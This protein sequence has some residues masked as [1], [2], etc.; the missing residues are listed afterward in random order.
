MASGVRELTGRESLLVWAGVVVWVGG[1]SGAV[2][3]VVLAEAVPTWAAATLAAVATGG[4]ML[5][6]AVV[7]RSALR[8][9]GLERTV[10]VEASALAFW[11]TMGG[12]L[13]YGIVDAFA[14]VPRLLAPWVLFF[15]LVS[16]SV[17]QAARLNRYR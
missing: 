2:L 17:A 4:L 1:I 7:G 10:N 6:A 12:V 14:D 8:R 9:D 5:T 11:I 3:L 13:T 16:W 15:G